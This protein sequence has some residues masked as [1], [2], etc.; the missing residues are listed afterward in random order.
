MQM[1]E[2]AVDPLRRGAFTAAAARTS[3]C[4][5]APP[6]LPPFLPPPPL[7]LSLSLSLVC[8]CFRALATVQA[9][10]ARRAA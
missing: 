9:A 1:R 10:A 5:R 4:A 2:S 3:P 8:V 6:S 7:S